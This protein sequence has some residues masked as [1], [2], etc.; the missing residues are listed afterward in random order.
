[1]SDRQIK[2]KAPG[3]TCLF[4]DHQDYLGLP[5][6]ACAI[7]RHIF[8]EA[9]PNTLKTFRIQ[10]KDID[11]QRDIPI[12]EKFEILQPRDYFASALRV[13]RRIGCFPNQGY[14]VDISGNIP[15]NAGNSSSSA[16]LLAWI[17]FLIEAFG[18][19][20]P[21]TKELLAELGY[22]AEIL[23]HN[24]PGGMMDH[25]S[26]A[27]GGVVHLRTK[28]PFQCSTIAR[29]LN[30]MVT[31]VSGVP[32][33]TVGLL[34]RVKG[35][36]MKSIEIISEKFSDFD[37]MNVSVSDMDKYL[38]LMPPDLKPYFEAAIENHEITQKA[39]I[40]FQ[41]PDLN[42]PKIGRLMTAHHS[43]LR[44]KLK[45]TVPKIDAMIDAVLQHGAYGAKI[46]G[47][48]GGGSIVALTEPVTETKIVNALLSV[49][50]QDAYPIKVD[51]GLQTLK[52]AKSNS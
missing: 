14:D 31:G 24:E 17:Y 46:V 42:L 2:I 18:I 8:L 43:I 16:V 21:I 6:I 29:Q 50:A 27:M 30:G 39:L 10:M 52:L 32:K 41:K 38:S 47:S 19:D 5:V 28:P 11:S 7:D 40:E 4:G 48:G 22:K 9:T 44:D 13:L 26:I 45:I 15:I 12:S 34:A 20:Q 36:A 35:N 37:I 3:R 49:G 51:T 23:E 25:F 33:E 1:M